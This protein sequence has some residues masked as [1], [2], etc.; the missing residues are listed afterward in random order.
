VPGCLRC[1]AVGAPRAPRGATPGHRRS[2]SQTR[3]AAPLAT[4]HSFARAAADPRS[5]AARGPVGF[6]G[7]S[8]GAGLPAMSRRRRPPSPSRR[9]SGDIAVR[10]RKPPMR[11]RRQMRGEVRRSLE[12]RPEV[13]CRTGLGAPTAR[14]R[15]QPGAYSGAVEAPSPL[16]H[17]AERS[18]A[19]S[20]PTKRYGVAVEAPA[21][22]GVAPSDRARRDL[23]P[24]LASTDPPLQSPR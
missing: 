3:D 5:R 21:P 22:C 4:R 1:R 23:L 15:M 7:S 18:R 14:R 12:T 9:S 13:R 8:V 19:T 20:H 10:N 6:D 16:R 24:K 11:R 2:E 17:R